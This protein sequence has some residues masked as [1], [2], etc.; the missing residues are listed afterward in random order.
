MSEKQNHNSRFEALD[1]IRGVAALLVVMFHFTMRRPEANYGF[2]LGV[3]AVDLFFLMSGFVI[4]FSLDRIKSWQDFV[5]KRFVRLYPTYWACMLITGAVLYYYFDSKSPSPLPFLTRFAANMTM[6]QA[7]FGQKD[8]DG[9]YWTLIVEMQFYII[10]LLFY[11]FQKLKVF[12]KYGLLIVL[13][14][15]LYGI[16]VWR[17]NVQTFYNFLTNYI[18]IINHFPVFYAGIIF[19]LGFKEGFSKQRILYLVISFFAQLLLF[20]DGGRSHMYVNFQTYI[21]MLISY[22]GVMTLFVKQK[23]NFIAIKPFLFLGQIS[24]TLYL[25]HQYLGKWVLIPI[26]MNRYHFAY[27]SALLTTLFLIIILAYLVH[28]LVEKQSSKLLNL[29]NK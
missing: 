18:P 24:Y 23:I 12:E 3:T 20:N 9:P 15:G 13:I 4:F 14:S 26:L 5:K 1:A 6:F 2:K 21:F 19:Y 8:L 7:W 22:F 25:L 10:M 28:I 16:D 11:Q 17:N 27:W 29:M